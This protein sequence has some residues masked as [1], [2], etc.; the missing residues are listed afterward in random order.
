MLLPRSQYIEGPAMPVTALAKSQ[1][2]TDLSDKM[3]GDIQVLKY[4]EAL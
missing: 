2:G 3:L 1:S 4:P